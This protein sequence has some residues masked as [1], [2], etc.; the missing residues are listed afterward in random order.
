M[1]QQ[2]LN[3]PVKGVTENTPHGRIPPGFTHENGALNVRPFDPAE[4]RLR[5]GK[6]PGSGDFIGSA[7]NGTN[8]IQRMIQGTTPFIPGLA[9]FLSNYAEPADI[10][11]SSSIAAA[12]FSGTDG[13]ILFNVDANPFI[14]GYVWNI[15]TGFVGTKI[16]NPSPTL[17]GVAQGIQFNA[18]NDHVIIAHSGT[19]FVRAHPWTE[20]TST[21]GTALTVPSSLNS[22]NA[23][24]IEFAP[25]ET[26]VLV[27]D[28]P[29][30][31][32]MAIYAWNDPGWGARTT[33][34]VGVTFVGN[35]AF[36]PSGSHLAV[37]GL[38]TPFLVVHPWTGS[39]LSAAVS[40]PGTLPTGTAISCA[41]SPDGNYVAVAHAVSPF[42]SVY[43]WTGSA[44]GT[45]VTDPSSLPAGT[46][47]DVQWSPDG[48]VILVVTTVSPFVEAYSWNNGFGTKLANP[49]TLPGGGRL[50]C[51][52]TSD[53]RSIF[54]GGNSGT[55][56][57]D[58][59]GINTGNASLRETTLA[60]V[61][62][63]DIFLSDSPPGIMTASTGGTDAL[64][65]NTLFMA[66]VEGPPSADDAAPA[67]VQRHIY[68]CDGSNYQKL[69]LTTNVV[70]AWTASAGAL[71]VDASGNEARIM[72]VFVG[73]IFLAGLVDDSQNWFGSATDNFRDFDTAPSN[74]TV[75]TA[76]TGNSTDAAKIGDIITCL[77]PHTAD[78]MVVGC[79]HEIHRMSGDP[80]DGGRIDAISRKVGIVGA[81]AFTLDPEGNLYYM[82]TNGFT[83]LAPNSMEPQLLSTGLL[84]RTFVNIDRTEIRVLLQWDRHRYGCHV[85]LSEINAPATAETHFWYDQRTGGF[86]PD[87]FPINNGPT[88]T[89]VFDGDRAVDR[90]MLLGGRDSRIYYL[91]NNRVDDTDGTDAAVIIDSHIDFGLISSVKGNRIRLDNMD[92]VLGSTSGNVTL[93]VF[94]DRTPESVI[95]E[96]VVRI[97]RTISGGRNR[98]IRGPITDNSLR[99]RMRQNIAGSGWT[100]EEGTVDV[101]SVGKVRG[102]VV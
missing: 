52:F 53:S 73:R 77:A 23:S 64:D 68:F 40:N 18:A 15:Q 63:G 54:I 51:R 22:G 31:S 67:N 4:D 29:T 7:I 26:H 62:G 1:P 28:T 34:T 74:P 94:A 98:K 96:T 19:P 43:N 88:A 50:S 86:I 70:S 49:G 59:Y 11:S 46:G 41:W 100:Y 13:H 85:F 33:A 20:S 30:G 65:T 14:Q 16:T 36:N 47:R 8:R 82:A 60:V 2:E 78:T 3:W 32:T 66:A 75:Q 21:F 12:A 76:I 38:T 99:I 97:A 101:K 80:G 71:P 25:S 5:G 90:V 45:K 83:K 42:I 92:I 27:M 81:D 89:V 91:D 37:S 17:A 95:D 48:R 102:G 39:T 72:A 69:N 24:Y 9:R 87:R 58:G 56:E 79:D 55:S 84:D 44:F 61:S 93:S 35:H 6:R 57:V 10:Q